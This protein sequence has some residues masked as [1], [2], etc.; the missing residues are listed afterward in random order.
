MRISAFLNLTV[1]GNKHIGVCQFGLMDIFN[2]LN[3]CVVDNIIVDFIN[4]TYCLMDI[5]SV[6]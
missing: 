5:N 6:S 3:S 2:P 1:V 4:L